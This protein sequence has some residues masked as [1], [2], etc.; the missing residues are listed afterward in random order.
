[1]PSFVSIKWL[2]CLVRLKPWLLARQLDTLLP[3][4]FNPPTQ[5]R[6][7]PTADLFCPIRHIAG[8][9]NLPSDYASRNPKE[10][11]DS[12]YQ[13]C[14][15]NVELEDSVVRSL[16]VSDV[17][18]GSVKMPFTSR[19][20]WQVIQ[21]ECPHLRRTY[22]H[23]SQGTRPSKKAT[24]IIDVE[25]MLLKLVTG[26]RERES[27]NECTAV[28]RVKIQH[29][30]QKKRKGNNL[31]KCEEVLRLLTWVSTGCATRSRPGEFWSFLWFS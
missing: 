17:L 24:K 4:S 29:G 14:K 9:E 1:M 8:V 27:G 31:G 13:I 5:P 22:S 19:A 11:L 16:S 7:S 6:Y 25:R 20:A 10:C 30:G 26:N 21:L 18:Q 12:S 15:F 2:D 23:L 28:T 3:I